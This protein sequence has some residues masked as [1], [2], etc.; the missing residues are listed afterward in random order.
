M[1]IIR[2]AFVCRQRI[3]IEEIQR[4][5]FSAQNVLG[6]VFVRITHIQNLDISVLAN[7]AGFV[8]L[9]QRKSATGK[10]DAAGKLEN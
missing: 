4:H 3:R 1:Y 9:A 6:S 2:F 5:I 8:V 7:K 10:I